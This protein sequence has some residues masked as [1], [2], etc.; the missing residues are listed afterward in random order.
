M[1]GRNKSGIHYTRRAKR[2]FW[3]LRLVWAIA[4]LSMFSSEALAQVQ[5][6]RPVD[7]C[8]AVNVIGN[9]QAN[10]SVDVPRVDVDVSFTF[11]PD[12]TYSYAA[13]QGSFPWTSHYGFYSLAP[14]RGDQYYRCLLQLIPNPATIRRN[15]QDPVRPHA[16]AGAES[17]GGPTQDVPRERQHRGR[18][19][20]VVRRIAGSK[21]RRDVFPRAGSVTAGAAQL[22]TTGE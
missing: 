16:A 18:A 17:A 6:R 12:G 22:S 20:D 10:V 19:V 13:G 1:S 3:V 11:R 14:N 15:P 5:G 9:W 21:R 8:R 4:A 7:T 2:L